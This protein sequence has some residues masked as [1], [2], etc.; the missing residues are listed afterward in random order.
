MSTAAP[1]RLD[2]PD[3]I[4]LREGPWQTVVWNDPSIS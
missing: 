4:A 3:A 1:E 2:A